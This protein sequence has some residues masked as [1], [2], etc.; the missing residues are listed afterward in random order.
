MNN[1]WAKLE[2]I[3]KYLIKISRR[4][5]YIEH[6]VTS[7]EW[8]LK[9]EPNAGEELKMAAF[10]HDIERCVINKMPRIENE[11]YMQYKTR[12]AQRSADILSGIMIGLE[13][14]SDIIERIHDLVRLHEIGGYYEAD[15]VRDADSLSFMSNN[16]P[17]YFSK[18]GKD[19]TIEKVKFMYSRASEKAKKLIRNIDYK[20]ELL[21]VVTRAVDTK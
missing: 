17:G 16:L 18:N 20:G 13:F 21:E 5:D 14:H 6:A 11:E 12:H 7:R 15:L 4:P 8:L 2:Q 9:I 10:A 3:L 19:K 1:K